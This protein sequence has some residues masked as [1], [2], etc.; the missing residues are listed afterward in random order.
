[1][2]W[3]ILWILCGFVCAM[4]AKEKNLNVPTWFALGCLLG[5]FAIVAIFFVESEAPSDDK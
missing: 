5:I 3:V 1:M 4:I 2:V